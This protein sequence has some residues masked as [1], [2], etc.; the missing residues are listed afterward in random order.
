MIIVVEVEVTDSSRHISNTIKPIFGCRHPALNICTRIKIAVNPRLIAIV[1]R[2]TISIVLGKVV[3]MVFM[4]DEA[5]DPPVKQKPEAHLLVHPI[6]PDAHEPLIRRRDRLFAERFNIGGPSGPQLL[7]HPYPRS[8][9][10][11]PPLITQKF[12]QRILVEHLR[13]S[14]LPNVRHRWRNWGIVDY[15]FDRGNPK[16]LLIKDGVV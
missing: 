4:D 1:R 16:L 3:T 7:H 13:V 2:S 14:E 8:F 5:W 15:Q 10:S 12:I 9:S 11:E 6:Q